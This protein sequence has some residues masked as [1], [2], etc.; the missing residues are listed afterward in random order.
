MDD[1]R[2]IQ[3]AAALLDDPIV[4][5]AS[6]SGRSAI[7]ILRVSGSSK[8]LDAIASEVIRPVHSRPAE[9][10]HVQLVDLVDPRDGSL[11]DRGLVVRFT[12]PASYTGEDV[13]ELSLH[14]NPVLLSVA[15][16][17]ICSAGAR[18][19]G[20]GE[21]T[22]R[23]VMHGK[24]DLVEAEGVDAVINAQSVRGAALAQRHLGGELSR[25]IARW[26]AD[27]LTIAAA[28]EALVDFPEE[29][30]AREVDEVLGQLALRRAEIARLSESFRAGRQLVAGWR[31]AITGP[32]NA[33]KSTL[34]NL[35][36]DYD[37]AIVSAQP[38]TTRDLVAET[39]EWAGSCLR[40][41]DTAGIRA[42]G[43]P[44]EREGISRSQASVQQADLVVEVR[45]GRAVG[46]GSD[47]RREAGPSD[48]AIPRVWVA[49]HG[50]LLGDGE[51]DRL[52]Q[53]GWLVTSSIDGGGLAL[54]RSEVLDRLRGDVADGEL[55]IHTVRQ[56]RALQKALSAIDE[57]V[58]YS[59]EEPALSAVALRGSIE[60]LGEL[61]DRWDNEEVLDAM[62]SRFCIGK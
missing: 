3:D 28:L 25:R 49:T 52:V 62:F 29:V 47:G 42:A 9:P 4:A 45:D 53:E 26:R 37:R 19:A 21:F 43:D 22:R 8:A 20:P 17:A 39:V 44:V 13:L 16:E 51:G 36:L 27:L 55:L 56:Q 24:M 15:L 5:I 30:E 34:F 11:I 38:G 58:G 7:G 18:A 41:E 10:R 61:S 2:R 59:G 1:S 40:I 32:V 35:L 23:A 46:P 57:A 48:D 6:A 14:G 54:L 60:S 12:G 50:D 33:G 31:V